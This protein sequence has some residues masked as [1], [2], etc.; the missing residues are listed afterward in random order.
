MFPRALLAACVSLCAACDP[1]P[2]V[3]I[4]LRLQDGVERPAAYKLLI[5]GDDDDAPTTHGPWPA[6]VAGAESGTA[7]VPVGEPFAI[8]AWGCAAGFDCADETTLAARGCTAVEALAA[9]EARDVT[10][11]MDTPA[12]IGDACPP[13]PR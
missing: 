9:G 7:S 13:D 8:D 1:S 4:T 5:R 11:D 6:D 12:A 3:R 2:H 10:I